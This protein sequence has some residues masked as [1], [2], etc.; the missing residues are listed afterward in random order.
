MKEFKLNTI[1]E[2]IEEIKKGNFV[3]VVDDEDRENEGDLVIAAECITPEKVNF[4]ETHARGLICA[5]ITKERAEELEL[6]MMVTHN[7]SIHSTPFTVSIDLLTHGCTTGIS[8]YDRAQTILALTRS[9]TKPEDFGR[10]GHIFPLRAMSKGV[11]RRAGHTEATIDLARLAGLYPAGALAEIK[12]EDGEMARLPELMK[13]AEEFNL[14]IISVADLIKYR[15]KTESLV[16]RGEEVHLPTLY[17]DFH[18]VPFRQKSNGLDHVAIIKGEWQKDEPILVR[19]HSS[20]A[21]GDIFGSM[22][23]ECGEQLHKALQMIEQE[24]KGVLVY[25]NQEG[26]GIGLMAKASAYKLQEEGLDTVD[27]NL[28]LGYKADERDYGVGA[29][30]LRNLGVTKMRLMTNNPVKRIGLESYGLEVVENVP[31][32]ITP[33]KYNHFYMETKKKKMGHILRNPEL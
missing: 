22:R 21:T 11:I 17:G 33:N 24:G 1:E 13:M 20:C 18:M 2:A 26:R 30:I 27:A 32:E 19:V 28:H 5:P 31:I 3:I 25:L 15:L 14:K 8:A 6:P 29:Q 7:T 4:M 16:D 12:K 23:C 9:E 10:P